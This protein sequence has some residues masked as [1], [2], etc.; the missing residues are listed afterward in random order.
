MTR[1]KGKRKAVE[2]TEEPKPGE[3][4]TEIPSSKS[5]K[6][7]PDVAPE[8]DKVVKKKIPRVLLCFTGSVATIKA[9]HVI[10]AFLKRPCDVSVIFT[11]A[12]KKFIDVDEVMRMKEE[13]FTLKPNGVF[14]GVFTDDTEWRNW[15]TIGDLV[16]HIELRKWATHLVIAPLSA[17]TLSKMAN[18]LCDNLLTCVWRAWDFDNQRKKVF[19][20]PAMNTAMWKNPFTGKHLASLTG[21]PFNV[22]IIDPA[23]KTLACGDTGVGAMTEPET[24]AFR[25][26]GPVAE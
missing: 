11:N 15:K 13:N 19:V 6:A 22:Q 7:K 5:K 9:K 2:L 21:F 3:T 10:A 23:E 1:G 16:M 25:V 26:L 18:G 20:A 8:T 14:K 24:I 17:N 4:S 12:A